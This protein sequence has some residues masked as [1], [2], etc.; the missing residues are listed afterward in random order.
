VHHPGVISLVLLGLLCL[1]VMQGC[2]GDGGGGGGIDPPPPSS[3]ARLAALSLSAADL[4]QVFQP[5]TT[6]YSATVSLLISTTT[7]TPA[8]DDANASV[9]V[10]GTQVV[11]GTASED[12]TL[13]E[14]DNTITLVVTAEDA[15]TTSTY[16]I[17]VTR[18]SAASFAQQAYIKA[19]NTDIADE[20]GDA[21]ALSGDTLAVG[22]TGEDGAATGIGG[23]ESDNSAINSGAVYVFTRDPAGVWSQQAYIKAS[24]AGAGDN[25]GASVAL[26]GD[27]LAVGAAL[28]DSASTG[29]DGDQDDNNESN[30][31]AVYVYTRDAA[32]AWSQQA[33]VK[34]SNADGGDHFG[35]SVSISGDTLAVGAYQEDS[36]ATG[37]DGD[38][39]D[40]NA[41]DAGAVYV[42]TRDGAGEWSQQA[43]VKASNTDIRD[44]FGWA[45]A[46]DGDTLA[47]GAWFEES[48]AIGVNGDQGDNSA[49]FSGAVYVFTR[50][51]ADAWSQQAYIKASNTEAM[52]EFGWS[53]SLSGDTLAVGARAEASAAT[54][55][56]GDQNDNNAG[57]SGAAYV[58]TRD[59]AGAWSQ[60]AYIKASNTESDDAFGWS[61]AVFDDVLAV[62]AHFEAS[63]AMGIN[64]N[65]A[66]ENAVASGAVYLFTR[67]G[68]NVW[69]QQAYVKA[70]NTGF[71]DEFGSSVSL[72]G[73]LLAV[74][75]VREASAATGIEGDQSDNTADQSG[76]A[77][78]FE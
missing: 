11:S 1:V 6:D 27:T 38:Q 54:G 9:T 70:S 50:D 77:Y 49:D 12:I 45:V 21:V 62:G 56:N 55:I 35:H 17:V 69:S 28:E 5:G 76:A 73:D 20:F 46:L 41:N 34:A 15:V 47:V 60:Q 16:T 67:D 78:V 39:S 58:F 65:Q 23:D 57:V 30:S 26:S 3:N 71:T 2:G 4:D 18:Q 43:Y 59:G 52:D 7:V 51:A 32:G 22:A 13:N 24:N 74:G 8:T 10:N 48:A 75:A 64:G 37:I 33:Y 29:I 31:G 19:S 53:V 42:F 66:D 25:F 61:L 14:G 40:E 68:A 36:A 63:A 72:A 44:F